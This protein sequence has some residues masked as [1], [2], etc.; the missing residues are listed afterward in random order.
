MTITS[1]KITKVST[2]ISWRKN[3]KDENGNIFA[4]M[5]ATIDERRPLGTTSLTV[6]DQATF[7]AKASEAQAAYKSFQT[8]VIAE[9]NKITVFAETVEEK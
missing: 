2:S 4:S 1:K 3:L 9:A 5:S 7:E 6:A 8:E